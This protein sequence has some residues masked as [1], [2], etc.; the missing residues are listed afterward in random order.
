MTTEN[1]GPDDLEFKLVGEGTLNP[2]NGYI[3]DQDKTTLLP[4]TL[5]QGSQNVRKTLASTIAPRQ[6][7]KVYDPL[8]TTADGIKASFDWYDSLGNQL[9]IRV[10]ASGKLQMLSNA[11]NGVNLVWYTLLSGLTKTRFIFDTWWDAVNQKDLLLAVNGSSSEFSWSGAFGFLSS[12]SVTARN[13]LWQIRI[14]NGISTSGTYAIGDVLTLAGGVGGQVTVTALTGGAIPSAVKL[15]ALGSGYTAGNGIATSGGGGTGMTIDIVQVRDTYTVTKTGA[16]T[17]AQLGF[18]NDAQTSSTTA[19]TAVKGVNTTNNR[20][21]IGGVEYAYFGGV[22]T[23]ILT[24]VG[25][26]TANSDPTGVAANSFMFQSI[27]EHTNFIS[28]SYLIDFIRVTNN[29]VANGSYSSR[30]VYVANASDFTITGSGAALPGYNFVL[31]LDENACGFAVRQGNLQIGAGLADWYEVSITTIALS[32][33]SN[34]VQNYTQINVLKRTSADLSAPLGQEFITNMGDDIVYLGQDHQIYIYGSFTDQFTNRFPSLSQA[35]R[36]ELVATDF[37]GGH[38]RATTDELN[39][40]APLSGKVFIYNS[41]Q[42]IDAK[43]SIFSERFWDSPQILNIS[44]IAVLNGKKYGYASDH[45]QMYQLNDTNQWHDDTS[46]GIPAAYVSVMRTAYRNHGRRQGVLEASKNYTEGYMP[47][48]TNLYGRLRYDYLGASGIDEFEVST[49]AK[50][51]SLYQPNEARIVGTSVVG[52]REIGG[53][54]PVFDYNAIP[55][56]RVINTLSE[57][58]CFEYQTE[59]YSVDAD[60]RWEILCFGTN[61]SMSD[62][63]AVEINRIAL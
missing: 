45:P 10:L 2:F 47:K 12:A 22:G 28:S 54:I 23:T 29:Q 37:T 42:N 19:N 63:Q 1:P 60:S 31:T 41:R 58:N 4:Q 5:V 7:K 61:A 34:I 33:A 8:D 16:S 46:E 49:T 24:G 14:P 26:Y 15:T 52:V 44:R 40:V 21:M 59:Y 57:P 6:G 17:F 13:S 30:V 53:A 36:T 25:G 9:A 35:V 32:P 51:A 48:N 3:S 39:L 43:G 62:Q 50:N 38:I 55:K 18:T 56:F 20:I 27:I 11:A